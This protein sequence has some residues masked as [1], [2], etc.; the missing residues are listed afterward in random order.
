MKKWIVTYY[1]THNFL[2]Y[3]IIMAKSS[4]DAIK[5]SRVKYIIDFRL[6]EEEI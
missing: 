1:K 3:K 5:K 2:T 6:A 4:R